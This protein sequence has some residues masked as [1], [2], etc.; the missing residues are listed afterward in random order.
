MK[1]VEQAGLVKFDFLSLTNLTIIQMAV[2]LINQRLD[3]SEKLDIDTITLEYAP[4]YELLAQ[5]QHNWRIPDGICWYAEMFYA[6]KTRLFRRYYCP[7]YRCIVPDQWRIFL[8]MWRVNMAG[9]ILN[10]YT[11]Y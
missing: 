11:L 2:N 9:K 1:F 3:V 5:R 10:T 6:I 7:W 4:A 8:L